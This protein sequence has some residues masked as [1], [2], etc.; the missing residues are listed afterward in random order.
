M[1]ATGQ[2][3]VWSGYPL[4]VVATDILGHFPES[5]SGNYV[6]I[7]VATDYFPPWAEAY[8]IPNQEAPAVVKK[9]T[10]ELFYRFPPPKQL[11]SGQG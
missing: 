6:Y 8:A 11:H 3:Q 2:H 7:L 5:V 4:Q 1:S 10:H 9:L